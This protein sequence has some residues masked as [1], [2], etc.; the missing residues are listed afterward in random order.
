[1]AL[2]QQSQLLGERAPRHQ[3]E[4]LMS[5]YLELCWLRHQVRTELVYVEL[6]VLR[7]ARV[8][9]LEVVLRD[10]LCL[11]LCSDAELSLKLRLHKLVVVTHHVQRGG[12]PRYPGQP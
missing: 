11:T 2:M 5:S 9:K 4:G 8:V 6:P 10:S 7:L 1:M 12:P 3:Y